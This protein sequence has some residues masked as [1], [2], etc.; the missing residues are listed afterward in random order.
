LAKQL[1]WKYPESEMV[2][3]SFLVIFGAM[4]FEKMLWSVS[5]DWLHGNGWT[6][7]VTNSGISTSGKAASSIGVH[8]ICRTR[9]IHQ[10][11]SAA[12]TVISL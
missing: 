12:L 1:Q 8:H 5:G 3:E 9:Y 2:E 7:V 6:T 4:H 11:T 10:V